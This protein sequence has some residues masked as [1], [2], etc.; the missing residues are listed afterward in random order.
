MAENHG[1]TPEQNEGL[2]KAYLTAWEI[3]LGGGHFGVS[4]FLGEARAQVGSARNDN[5]LRRKAHNV[6]AVLQEAELPHYFRFK[7]QANRQRTLDAAV[8][9][10]LEHPAFAEVIHLAAER[11]P[12]RQPGDPVPS[13]RSMEEVDPPKTPLQGEGQLRQ[14]SWVRRA[15]QRDFTAYE[16]A[17]R[18]L[19][20]A[21]EKLAVEHYK[22]TLRE[23]GREDLAF[24]VEH[25]A[26]TQGDGLGYDVIAYEPDGSRVLVEVKTTRGG[27]RRPFFISAAEVRASEELG[28]EY[29]LMRIF[30]Y[31]S[32]EGTKFY[33]L[34][35]PI[36]VSCALTPVS[37]SAVPQVGLAD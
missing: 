7:P 26:V 27:L 13:S 17:N 29:R 35:G 34:P 8:F 12:T 22:R 25:A 15:V 3:E 23:A 33:T 21:G 36:G 20:L 14:T 30:D 16:A 19:G 11:P 4:G 1:W 2:V 6:S 5:A 28:N 9:S 31:E 37:Y 18:S 24:Q 32:G 10:V